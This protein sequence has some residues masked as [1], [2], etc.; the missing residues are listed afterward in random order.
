MSLAQLP[1]TLRRAA[2]RFIPPRMDP[3]LLLLWLLTLPALVPLAMPGYFYGAHD[4]R[5]SVFYLL[6]F[7]AGLRDG[8]LWPRWAMHHIQGYGYPT[9]ILQAPLGFYVAEFFVLLGAGYTAAVKWTWALGFLMS[10]WGMYALVRYWLE[11]STPKEVRQDARLA[12]LVAGLLYVYIP[13]HLADIYVRAALNDTLLLAWFPWVFLTFDRLIAAGAAP[14]WPRRLALA[15]LTL[16]GCLLTHTFALLSFTPLVMAF[17]L[18]RLLLT[19]P[20]RHWGDFW[21]RVALAAAAGGAGLL[22]MAGFLLPLLVEG[23]H[24]EQQVYIS[25]TYDYRNHFVHWGQFFSP[26]WGFGYSDD[27][28]G[29]NDGMG[30]QAGSLALI[31]GAVGGY[32]LLHGREAMGTRRAY[33]SFLASASIV[34]LFLMTSAAGLLWNALPMLAVIQFPWRLLALTA[35]TLSALGGPAVASLLES[36]DP[37]SGAAA[38]EAGA[39]ILALLVVFASMGYVGAP[40]E[41]VEAWR[42]DGRAIFRFEQEHPDMIA[43]TEWVKEPFT[44]SPMTEDYAAEEYAEDYSA[45][46]Q[47]T[48]L[49]IIA[50]EGEIVSQYSRGSSAGGVVR[51]TGPATVRVHL[52]YFPGWQVRVDGQAVAARVSDPYGLIEVDVPGGEHRIDVR[53]GATPPRTLGALISWATLLALLGLWAWDRSRPDSRRGVLMFVP[54]HPEPPGRERPG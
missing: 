41:P 49:A 10:G 47:L 29:A 9:F 36:C 4:G 16:A 37:Q 31:L 42:E 54:G 46:G 52:T 2:A 8:A 50:G 53:M 28:A 33:L 40:L 5:H 25:N 32:V 6:Q 51:T 22:L 38:Q 39:L 27:P 17:V 1:V 20:Q 13:Y 18:F 14:G 11:S 44:T 45:N 7:D 48:R 26:Q 12:A 21:R 43:Y 3:Y 35:F 15:A 23:P 30:F 34:L 24:L 19:G